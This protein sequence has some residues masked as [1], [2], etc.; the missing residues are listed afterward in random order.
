MKN[1][2][3][4]LLVFLAF[5]CKTEED[6][7]PANESTFVRYF[8]SEHSHVA[9]SAIEADNGFTL[10]STLQ[11]PTSGLG[12]FLYKIRVIHTDMHGNIQ[13]AQTF[14][15]FEE[16]EYRQ[17]AN[18]G[19]IA[20]SFIHLPGKGY[21]IIGDRINSN[22]TTEL[23]LLEIDYSGVVQ[24]S[25]RLGFEGGQL[26]GCAV[27]LAPDDQ[28]GYLILG[29]IEKENQPEDMYV[30]RLT[31][32]LNSI[33]WNRTYGDGTSN[34]INRLFINDANNLIWGASIRLT[35]LA[36]EDVR[37]F[38]AQDNSQ[39][40]NNGGTFVGKPL[41]NESAQD[42]TKSFAG[43]AVIGSKQ[44]KDATGD[45]NILL[46]ILNNSGVV[47]IE[48]TLD[49]DGGND[50]GNSISRTEDGSFISLATVES[51]TKGNGGSDL[52]IFKVGASGKM[53][54]GT[55]PEP[56][57]AGTAL[58]DGRVILK[59]ENGVYYGGPDDEIGASV[60]ET[61][62]GGY[63]IFG[64]TFYGDL[65]KLMLLKVNSEGKL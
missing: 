51:S 40:T 62:D 61:S 31:P 47:T 25:A 5:G 43:Y 44:D 29:K 58:D 10:I 34:P 64:T 65:S 15:S 57:V 50:I 6:A 11:V 46:T 12:T 60:I 18:E 3:P 38:M 36:D 17:D 27:A 21:L 8:G 59:D 42:L 19:F 4:L 13:W 55:E 2:L 48:K 33:V 35:P 52:F 23:Q 49:F 24:D 26:H 39:G 41:F 28:P 20:S 16:K 63:L 56:P 53:A 45:A 30:A 32:D 9:K 14:P 54:W 7:G 1:I 22:D 37:F